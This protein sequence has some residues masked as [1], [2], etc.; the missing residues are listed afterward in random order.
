MSPKPESVS[1]GG[2]SCTL[3]PCADGSWRWHYYSGGRRKTASARNLDDARQRAKEHLK[4]LR[5]GIPHTR[6][7]RA[8]VEE[9]FRW[10]QSRELSVTVEEAAKQYLDSRTG[11]SDHHLRTLKADVDKFKDRHAKRKISEITP[12]DIAAHLDGQKGGPRRRNNIRGSLIAW[13][14]W[15]R[16]RQLLPDETVVVEHVEKLRV[17]PKSIELFTPAELTAIL[18]ACGD[19]WQPAI[20]IQAFCGLR[21]EEVSRLRWSAVMPEKK[22]IEVAASISKTRRRRLVPMPDNLLAWL[23]ESVDASEMVAPYEGTEPLIKRLVR[24]GITWKK[25]GLRHA[26]GSYRCAVLRDVAQVAFEMGNS[27]AIVMSH[28]NEAQELATALEW[29]AILPPEK[30]RKASSPPPK[31]NQKVT[32]IEEMRA[33]A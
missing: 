8:D 2:L 27:P 12:A 14:R 1:V 31:C 26:F 7:N 22:L 6:L 3:W 4:A 10:K 13:F 32:S 16:S 5:S 15:C 24:A 11:V 23:P 25:N 33:V 20:A 29:F 30:R 21:T 9:F 17:P 18:A 28:Y 19:D